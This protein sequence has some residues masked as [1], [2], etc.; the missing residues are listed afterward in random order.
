MLKILAVMVGIFF[1]SQLA[2]L[3]L[4]LIVGIPQ[5][6]GSVVGLA[7]GFWGAFLAVQVWPPPKNSPP[8]AEGDDIV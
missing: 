2:G 1:A 8:I 3:A 7:F 5:I 4:A 6:N